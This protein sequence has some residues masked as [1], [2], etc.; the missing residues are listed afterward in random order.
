MEIRIDAFGRLLIP[1]NIRDNLG[2]YAGSVM[3]LELLGE[4]IILKPVQNKPLI[5]VKGGIS[6]YTGAITGDMNSALQADRNAR[7]DHLGK[8]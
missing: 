5:E 1:K 7:L 4:Q 8:I 2:L 3:D 6:V